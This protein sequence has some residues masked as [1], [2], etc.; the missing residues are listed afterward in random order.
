MSIIGGEPTL[1]MFRQS[2]P[3]ICLGNLLSNNFSLSPNSRFLG[4]SVTNVPS[5]V[6]VCVGGGRYLSDLDGI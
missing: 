1:F 2:T 3:N 6:C 5:V 4:V